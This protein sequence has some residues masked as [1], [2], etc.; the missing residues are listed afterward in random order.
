MVGLHDV[1]DAA[2]ARLAVDPDHGLVV[3]ADVLGVD[4]QVRNL[5][6]DVVDV[7]VGLVRRDLHLVEALVDGVLMATGERGVHQIAAVRMALVHTE[8]VAVL[9]RA[10][11]LVD[12]GEVDLRI[13]PAT[14][15]VH[16]ERHQADIAG[17]LAVAEQAT[18]DAVG[19][20]L[21]AEFGSGDGSSAIV[22]RM[23]AQDH[24]V[25]TGEVAVHPLDR[26]G[27]HVGGGHLHGC[28]EVQDDRLFRCGVDDLGDRVTHLFGVGELCARVRLRGVF[29][30]PIGVGVLDFFGADLV[31]SVGGDFLDGCLVGAEDH[32]ALQHRRRI[33]EVHNHIRGA[34][35]RIEGAFDQFVA[36]LRQDLDGDVRRD[37]VVFDDLADEVVVGLAG[38]GEPHLDLLVTHPYQQVE[39]AALACRAHRVDQS[40]IPV[41][42]V[43]G[44]PHG[45][46]VDHLV[47]PGAVG[48]C[49]V[50]DLIGKRAV[51]VGRHRGIA[52]GVP[53]RLS[54]RNW[55]SGF[56][57]PAGTGS[58]CIGGRHEGQSPG[59]GE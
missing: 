15:Q 32:P 43:D 30:T 54:G 35:A 3:A 21:V 1:G 53:R 23:Q 22:V 8:L 59:L 48:D 20:G 19:A 6:Q 4:R 25:A 12:V 36:A 52:L 33:V 16:A 13:D 45:G 11:D 57:D 41:T 46:A 31:S 44:A 29:V 17:S 56:G 49:D 9:D 39:H 14:E 2:L 28:R 38:R 27:I 42:K 47:G 55:S 37:R 24:R 18:L 5:P 7:R 26:V 50:L 40:L 10:A 34:A 58:E 51:P